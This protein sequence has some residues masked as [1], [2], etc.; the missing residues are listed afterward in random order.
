MLSKKMAFSLTSLI[1]ILALA[2]VVT[3]AMAGEFGVSMSIHPEDDI[4]TADNAQADPNKAVR[5]RV[6]FDK[7]VQTGTDAADFEL[8]DIKVYAQDKYG[9]PKDAP[10]LSAL[11]NFGPGDGQNYQFTIAIPTAGTTK[12]V[13]YMDKHAVEVADPRHEVGKPER[14][15]AAAALEITYL[16][17]FDQGVP[18]VYEIRRASPNDR[19]PVLEEKADS[20]QVVI[21]LSEKPKE[22]K[23]DHIDVSNATAGDPV[24]LTPKS[25][26]KTLS[27][28][29]Q[30]QAGVPKM[31]SIYTSTDTPPIPGLHAIIN[32]ATLAAAPSN[33]FVAVSGAEVNTSDE[34]EDKVK[35]LL[36]AYRTYT[37]KAAA[38]NADSGIPNTAFGQANIDVTTARTDVAVS[39]LGETETTDTPDSNPPTALLPRTLPDKKI[40]LSLRKGADQTPGSANALDTDISQKPTAPILTNFGSAALYLAEQADYTTKNLAYEA[41]E[42]A[43]ALKAA[44]KACT[45]QVAMEHNEAVQEYLSD[46]TDADVFDNLQQAMPATGTDKMLHLYVVTITPKFENK[47]EIV[48]KVKAFEDLSNPP[49]KYMPPLTDRA[50]TEGYDKLTVKIG[51]ES[52]IAL[53]AGLEIL[54]P[55]EKRIPNGGYLVISTKIADSGIKKPA[56]SDKDE[57]KANERTPAQLL[58]N[59]IEVGLPN[60]RNF[61]QNG[62]TIDVVAPENVIISEIMWGSDASVNPNNNSQWIEL[63]NNSGKSLLTGDKTYKLMFY[64]PNEMLPAASTVKD[65]V[66]TVGAGGYWSILGKG[67]SGRSGIDEDPTT[68]AAVVPTEKLVSMQRVVVDGTDDGTMQASWAASSAPALNFDPSKEGE[69]I[70]TPGAAPVAYPVAPTPT[71]DPKPAPVVPVAGATDIVIT[72]IMVDTGDGRLPQ[73]IELTNVSKA[74]KSLTDWSV[75]IQNS[76]DDTEVVGS[77]V[78]IDLSGT[79]GVGGGMDKGG[80]MGKTLLLTAWAGRHSSNLDESKAAGRIVDVSSDVG[81]RGRYKLISDK[82]FMIALVPPQKTGVRTYGDKAGN[83]DAA[84]AWDIPMDDGNGRSSLIRREKD[85]ANMT[86]MGTDANGWV[87]AADTSLISGAATWFGSDEDAGTPG[88]DSGGPLPVELSHFRPARDKQTGAVVITWS[89]Q[90]EL[91]NAGFFIKRSQQRNG[92]FKVINAA[93]IRGFGTTSEKQ[94]YT[95]TDTTAQPNVVYYY[96]IEDVSLDGQRQT[97]THGIRLKGH[98]GAAGKA[99]TTWGEL[100]TSHE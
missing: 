70:G 43:K 24:A 99:T 100:K 57:P 78:I 80:T 50:Y 77:S 40:D 47:N 83:L 10:A 9:L 94:T 59:V 42:A 33:T 82:A 92:E 51:K 73:W 23:K 38:A 14:K 11:G 95:Y 4:S 68:Q 72:E 64:A 35:A 7:I 31:L 66:G 63:K 13:L 54:I 67:Q 97:L 5:V 60:L 84:E 85:V 71:P 36:M 79:L 28:F 20:F 12:L 17:D 2:F 62:G 91:N 55:K 76:D 90:S 32:G 26:D 53:G 15:S 87:L 61:L 96:Q 22:F 18:R 52:P 65:R 93:M 8:K 27:Q 3:P 69:R 58:Y 56:G 98:V 49:M 30:D 29:G 45:D 41:Y 6:K 34:L 1:T 21:T 16:Q 19:L 75:L 48:V 46:L 39:G 74:E 37:T 86:T 81:E 25:T 88:S 44:Y 89:T